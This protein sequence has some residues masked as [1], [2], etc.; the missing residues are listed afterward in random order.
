MALVS[1]P[2]KPFT[3]RA[4][5]PRERAITTIAV[6]KYSQCP[7]VRSSRKDSIGEVSPSPCSGGAQREGSERRGAAVALRG[8]VVRVA[9]GAAEVRLQGTH[10][11]DVGREPRHD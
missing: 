10:A 11:V 6:A 9:A 5:R 8:G 4:G 7:S 2:A 3:S 1:P